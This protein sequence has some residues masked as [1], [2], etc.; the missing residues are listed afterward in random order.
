MKKFNLDFD[1]AYQYAVA[2]KHDLKI[3]SFDKD[4]DGAEKGKLTPKEVLKG[5]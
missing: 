3:I 4:F 5:K 2:E 1:G